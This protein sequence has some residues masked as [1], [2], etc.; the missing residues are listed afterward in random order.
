MA[1]RTR[2]TWKPDSRGYYARQIGWELSKS[3]KLQQ[4]K[5]LL[6]TDRKEA[7]R[8]ERKL[9]ELWDTFSQGCD[10][11]RPLWPEDLLVI[12][13]RIAKGI[14]EIPIPRGPSE[15]QCD[16]AARIQR[17]QTKYPVILF[18]PEDQHAFE[19]GQ[20]A[21][22]LFEA[23]PDPDVSI[24]RVDKD[25]VDALGLAAQRLADA[26]LTIPPELAAFS[27]STE[28]GAAQLFGAMKPGTAA[29]R[30]RATKPL[31]QAKGDNTRAPQPAAS[32][33]ESKQRSVQTRTSGA[34]L[35]QALR[36]YEKY[37]EREYYRPET[38]Q[39]TPWGRTQVRQTKNLR[40]HHANVL[41]SKLDADTV[42]ELIGYWRRRPCKIG[43]K[44]PMTA[45][46]AS[47]YIGTLVRFLKW[48]D[49]SSSF[50]WSKPF[51]LSDM[52]TRVRRLSSDHDRKGLEQVDTFSLEELRLLMRY[53]QPFERL[54]LLL[55]L[56]CGFGRAEISTLLVR[57]AQLYQGHTK[58]HREIMA[59]E[60]TDDD[61]FI[62]RVR[63]KSGVYGEHILWPMTVQGVEWALEQ[64]ERFPE[65]GPDARLLLSE[66]GTALDKQ[67]K[68]GNANQLIPNHWDRLVKRIIDDGNAIR[69][70]SFGKLRKTGSDLVRRMSDGEVAAVFE[71]HG[72]PV[73]NDNLSDLYTNRPF[74]KVFKAIRDVEEFLQPMFKEA[75]QKPFAPQAQAYTKRSTIDRI[76]QLHELNYPTGQIAAAVGLSG[77][78]VSRHIQAYRQSMSLD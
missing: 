34:T 22:E 71:C 56:N 4:H 43:S 7:E 45:K 69:K 63:R 55:G 6:G 3:G 73:R 26:G 58:N 18:L 46:S 30:P 37:L 66:K 12:A 70:L 72:T 42:G 35:H 49:Q 38:E 5:F 2:R 60:T 50:D 11:E 23:V 54:L 59:Y 15:R 29:E 41:L 27:A 53:A 31:T 74:G 24:E 8:R 10:D 68:S 64:R 77:S 25:V 44:E 62:K 65:F 1:T 67:T 21:L 16:Y 9:R 57:E 32:A 61:S 40:K 75:G 78:A 47:N 33:D 51:A 52:D 76:I 28:E 13:K 17:M 39:I 14:P 48:L 36:A 19:I 20:A